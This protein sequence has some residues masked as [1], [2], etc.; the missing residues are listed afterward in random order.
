MLSFTAQGDTQERLPAPGEIAD[1]TRW[2]LERTSNAR[3]TSSDQ[4]QT[5][6]GQPALY[7]NFSSDEGYAEWRATPMLPIE[8]ETE[9]IFSAEVEGD[10][11]APAWLSVHGFSEE[12][13]QEPKLLAMVATPLGALEGFR[14]EKRF[15]V[16]PG[17]DLLRVGA[18]I[19]KGQGEVWFSQLSLRPAEGTSSVIHE[20]WARPLKPDADWLWI[21]GRPEVFHV[22]FRRKLVLPGT[23]GQAWI[24][25]TADNIFALTINGE[26]VGRGTEWKEVQMIDITRFLRGGENE[27]V[28]DVRNID[29][30]A[31]MLLAGGTY[32]ADH[33]PLTFSSDKSW[34]AASPEGEPYS[35]TVLGKAPLAPWRTVEILPVSPRR[36]VAGMLADASSK[37]LAGEAF[38]ADITLQEEIPASLL[39]QLKVSFINAKGERGALSP[40][41]PTIRSDRQKI[42]VSLPTSR[43]ANPGHY[44]WK[45]EAPGLALQLLEKSSLEV[46]AAPLPEASPAN[47]YIKGAGNKVSCK[48]GEQSPFT[49]A[50]N[51]TTSVENYQAWSQTG[52]HFF[53]IAAN[54]T[55]DFKS[56][57][58]WDLFQVETRLLQVLEADPDAV[59]QLRVKIDAPAW[60]EQRHPGD[61]FVSNKGRPAKQSFASTEW[62]RFAVES[63]VSLLREL[64]A[65]PVG[66]AVAS[67]LPM[68]FKGGEFQLWGEEVGEYDCSPAAQAA[69]QRWQVKN[70]VPEVQQIGLPHPALEYPFPKEGAELRGRFFRFVGEENGTGITEIVKGIKAEMPS[71]QV[72][73]YYG[74][75]H[76]HAASI[77][78]LLYGGSLGFQHVLREAPV[79]CIT[80]PA[81]YSLRG[82]GKGQAFMYPVTSVVL[83]GI[84][85]GVEDDIRNFL[86]L[87]SGDSSGERLHLPSTTILSLRKLRYLAAE[88]GA[89]VRYY[90]AFVDEV[91]TLQ[92]PILLKELGRVNHEVMNLKPCPVGAIGQVAYV[93][94]PEALV[95]LAELAD[96][97]TL[98]RDT[99]SLVRDTLS[100]IGRPV[101]YVTFEDWQQH[102]QKWDTIVLSMPGLLEPKQ[103]RA[104]DREFGELPIL[105][106][107]TPYLVLQRKGQA[108]TC[109]NNMALGQLLTQGSEYQPGR[110]WYIGGNFSIIN[111]GA[112][113]TSQERSAS[114]PQ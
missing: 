72:S 48:G 75:L 4:T 97:Q 17:F 1:N 64:E 13:K 53:E 21:E 101:A 25:V 77:K 81:S 34:S 51:L 57:G 58:R 40:W 80:C 46:L 3:V 24:Q 102:R 74:Y 37:I 114:S 20:P 113:F 99:L 49:Y 31:G 23:P 44:E 91:D 42:W 107:T 108:F 62:R 82:N 96:G 60:W 30:A 52:G 15:R 5:R 109:D 105:E 50:P 78:R 104:L 93:V 38:E 111:H 98:A 18:G 43:F 7:L 10:V 29:G 55:V 88:H 95:G 70:G 106:P 68:A 85:P 59:V 94:A 9:W 26:E 56:N 6:N 71:V 76:E 66:R 36:V 27:I 69:F 112:S 90:T 54:S 87:Q 47:I 22:V 103:L 16:P 45:L 92:S 2:K 79:D 19:S 32:F 35:L 8:A 39:N 61:C 11:T 14:L 73:I 84:Q 28:M 110:H 65:R 33:L 89:S 100:S 86:S 41:Q 63:V 67:V 12:E 83:H